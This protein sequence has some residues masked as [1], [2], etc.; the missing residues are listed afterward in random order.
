MNNEFLEMNLTF[1]DCC[2]LI[3]TLGFHL[4]IAYYFY[5]KMRNINER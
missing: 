1:A 4:R 5:E 2:I 3:A